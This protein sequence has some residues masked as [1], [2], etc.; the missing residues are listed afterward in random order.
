VDIDRDHDEGF[1]QKLRRA[2]RR[3]VSCC[4]RFYK[5]TTGVLGVES[6]W[7]GLLLYFRR[8]DNMATTQ[9]DFE[10]HKESKP[11]VTDLESVF[12][13]G[14]YVSLLSPHRALFSTFFGW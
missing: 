11:H 9:V 6:T 12:C 13:L 8:Q 2:S 4:L 5:Y 7:H 10:T 1:I 14:R 3:H